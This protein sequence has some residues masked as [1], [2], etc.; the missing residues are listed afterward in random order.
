MHYLKAG[1]LRALVLSLLAA[2]A[3]A[4]PASAQGTCPSDWQ[5]AFDYDTEQY[6]FTNRCI[7]LSHG[8]IHYFDEVP[9]GTQLGTVLMLHGNPSWSFLYRNIAQQLLDEGYRVVAPD[10][11]GFGL[12]DKPALNEFGYKPIDHALVV[13]SFVLALSLQDTTMVV[14]DWG[15]PIG[16][17]AADSLSDRFSAY[18]ILDTFLQ[19]VRFQSP[20][21][22]HLG[23]DFSLDQIQNATQWRETGQMPHDV[24]VNLGNKNG[25][26]GSAINLAV[27]QAYWG[28]FLNLDTGM[29]LSPDIVAPT[30]ILA[31]NILLS[32]PLMDGVKAALSGPISENPLYMVWAHDD[33]MWGALRCD[34]GNTPECPTG[35]QC[36][37]EGG[38]NYCK[39][40][41][42]SYF[43]P[44]IRNIRQSWPEQNIVDELISFEGIH[45]IQE[46]EP[47]AIVAAIKAVTDL[48]RTTSK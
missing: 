33:R 40:G 17:T 28:P 7:E 30:N 8:T 22:N 12:S 16:I 25:P 41:G 35:T 15:G 36:V 38:A 14:H 32:G 47:E 37:N 42:T 10:Y 48:A 21:V 39:V 20:G 34:I 27:K 31:Q 46:I 11:Y 2:T 1:P 3:F 5:P 13:R 23:A 19:R 24:G 29:P 9:D 45:F 6:P 18:V 4:D 26:P 43:Y 44:Q